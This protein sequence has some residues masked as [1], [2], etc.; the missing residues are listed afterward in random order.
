MSEYVFRYAP[1]YGCDMSALMDGGRE[2]VGDYFASD[3]TDHYGT[4]HEEIVRC[5]D[6]HW[7]KFEQSDHE[8]RVERHC[9]M[10]ASDVSADGFCFRGMRR[11]V[12]AHAE[13]LRGEGE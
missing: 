5:R 13:R 2:T 1:G 8:Y 12:D 7:S 3:A 11:N 10:W 6:C 9:N 4:L